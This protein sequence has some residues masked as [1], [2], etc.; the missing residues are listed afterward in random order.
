MQW[1]GVSPVH[2]FENIKRA[3]GN[4]TQPETTPTLFTETGKAEIKSTQIAPSEFI[5]II[6]MT[7]DEF[8]SD[9]RLSHLRYSFMESPFG[10]LIIASTRKGICYIAFEEDRN[11]ALSALQK[12]YPLTSLQKNTPDKHRKLMEY[13]EDPVHFRHNIKL[14]LKATDFQLLVWNALLAIPPGEIRSYQQLARGLD[15]PQSARAVGTAIGRNVIAYFIPCH[16]VVRSSGE[17]GKFKWGGTER[18]M[19]IIGW[20]AAQNT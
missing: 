3:Q 1:A 8:I 9:R 18:K 6:R 13:F 15:M 19:A 20:E 4:L 2:F 16:R 17:I 5:D 12:I 10:Q 14:H 11:K 7:D